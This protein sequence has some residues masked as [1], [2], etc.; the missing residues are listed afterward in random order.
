LGIGLF[1]GEAEE[2]RLD[3]VIKDA[4]NGKLKALYNFVDAPPLLENQPLPKLNNEQVARTYNSYSSFDL[5][6]GCPFSCSFCTI[7]N[8]QGK[9]SRYRTADDLEKII[10][11][12][13][14]QGINRF[15]LTDD[16]LARN[17]NWEDCLNRLVALR[18]E[19]LSVR[20]IAQV[21]VKSH[22]I[23][24]F[25]DKAVKAGVD[26]IFIGLESVSPQN[27][28]V[29]GKRQNNV[30]Q[31]REMMMA[32]KKHPVV[33]TAGYIIGF[34]ND[35]PESIR[36]DVEILKNDLPLDV[37]YFTYLTPLPG[38]ADHKIH[39]EN[40][41][42]LSPDLNRY[43]LNHFVTRHPL[44]SNE[45]WEEAYINAWKSFYSFR[46]MKTILKRMV[47][48]G[49]NKKL[50]TINRL[51]WHRDF[52]KLH[53]IHPLEGGLFRI[54]RRKDRRADYPTENR[55]SF[56]IY[57]LQQCLFAPLRMGMTYLLLR[58]NLWVIFRDSQSR[59]W[60]DA[61][62]SEFP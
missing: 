13:Y 52:P 20:L 45:Q 57:W 51:V 43:D 35:T 47:A 31:Y 30:N 21:D 38:S 44:M 12:N 29:I 10:R 2:G 28:F 62:I 37:V 56:S 33:I 53:N 61:A 41:R 14:A 54:I 49:S 6:R 11:E 24:G 26:Q 8:V 60:R 17:R 7:I 3:G 19:G 42:W 39:I 15:F 36:R 5:G 27:L 46:H 34:P 48:L 50:T 59:K 55:F 1:S 58:L 40:G 18:D 32:W 16:N 4:F 23:P 9:K 25:V 22:K